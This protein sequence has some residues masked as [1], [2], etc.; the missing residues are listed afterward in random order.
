MSLIARSLARLRRLGYI[1]GVVERFIA[2]VGERGQG[3]HRDLFGCIDIVAAKRGSPIL[4]VQATSL[5][6][7]SARV[8][9]ATA[10]PELRTWLASG[11]GFQVWGWLH[12]EGRW[13][14]KVV[15]VRPE[16]MQAVV[17]E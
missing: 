1:A 12:R 6:N 5:S 15:E 10:I 13:L 14:V 8:A 11:A 4:G 2:G 7:I 16:D 17:I 3:I 9:K